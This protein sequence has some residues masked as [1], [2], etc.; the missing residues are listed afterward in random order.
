[1]VERRYVRVIAALVASTAWM[2]VSTLLVLVNRHILTDLGF[3][4]PMTVS[5]L[6]MLASSIASFVCCRVLKI[7]ACQKEVSIKIYLTRIV[8]IG[9]I[10]AF[11]LYTGNQAN[12]HLTVAFIQI[13]KAFTPV[14]TMFALSLANVEQPNQIMIYAVGVVALGTAVAS[15]GELNFSLLG[16]ILVIC[17][18]TSEA[19]RMVMTQYMLVSLKFHPLEGLMYLAPACSGWL[20]AGAVLVEWPQMAASGGV[21]IAREYAGLFL[22]AAF[23]GF[24]INALA[25]TT[26]KLAS[27]V[28][29]KVLGIVRN[30][31]LVVFA[32]MFRGEVVT[33]V[34]GVGYA[35][36][37]LG[38]YA[39]NVLKIQQ[40]STSSS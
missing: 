29:L 8:P 1:M 39:Y 28:T 17:A 31:F 16:L 12:L 32:V 40:I 30:T 36:S 6:G 14:I 27:S 21:D 35:I 34:Q 38:F 37:L 24:L 22:L 25:Y 20:M 18:E 10:M 26:I 3:S 9:F 5:G 13:L 4:Y 11:T 2:T 15:Y 19:L 7:V 23:M 33:Q